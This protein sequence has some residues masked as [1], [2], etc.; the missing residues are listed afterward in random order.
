MAD[1]TVDG[2]TVATIV[3]AITW[4]TVTEPPDLVCRYFDAEPIT[5]PA[6]PT[7]L[8]T[9]VMASAQTT[10]FADAVAAATDPAAWTVTQKTPL[11]VDALPATLVEAVAL[12][13]AAGIPVGTTRFAYFVNV[14]ASGTVTLWTQGNPDDAAYGSLT[15]VV[16]L[17]TGL[18]QFG[19]GS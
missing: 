11:T 6:D 14:G 1:G 13:D 7:T 16:S 4:F 19:A 18:S 8:V 12:T 3:Y 17:M 2:T 10:P 15:G 5:V 9:D